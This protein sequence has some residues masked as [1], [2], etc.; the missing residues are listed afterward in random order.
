MKV[1][2]RIPTTQYGFVEVVYDNDQE[3]AEIRKIHNELLDAFKEGPENVMSDKELTDYI[4]NA[5]NGLGNSPDVW[6][7]MHPIQKQVLK[8]YRN[9]KERKAPKPVTN[10]AS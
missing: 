2:H 6:E 3:A 7:T 8:C 4:Y 5:L 9:A 1:S 10:L